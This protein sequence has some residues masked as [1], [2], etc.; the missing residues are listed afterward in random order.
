M[1]VSEQVH[2]TACTK[3]KGKAKSHPYSFGQVAKSR[4]GPRATPQPRKPLNGLS[5]S[6]VIIIPTELTSICTLAFK[7]IKIFNDLDCLF[8][9]LSCGFL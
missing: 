1:R 8:A 5:N 4:G 3:I 2:P 7:H 6:D 9:V